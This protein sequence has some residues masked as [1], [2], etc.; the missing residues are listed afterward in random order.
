M[1]I[2]ERIA[3][4]CLVLLLIASGASS[5]PSMMDTVEELSSATYAGRLTGTAGNEMAAH[6]LAA[7]FAQLGLE[8]LQG[9]EDYYQPYRQLTRRPQ[10]PPELA[11]LAGTEQKTL[12]F[13]HDFV[14]A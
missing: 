13:L 3:M 6:Y 8:P 12:R 7:H 4:A 14:V 9:L 1:R 5:S 10:S 11:I 2:P